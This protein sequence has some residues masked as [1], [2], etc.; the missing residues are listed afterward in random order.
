MIIDYDGERHEFEFDDI[1][2]KQAMKIEKHTGLKLTDWGDAL[3]GEDGM[4]MQ[5]LQ[6]LGWLV[7]S[8]GTGAVDDAD[9]KLAPFG[10]AFAAALAAEAAKRKAEEDAERPT[11][12]V[13]ASN[14]QT[15]GQEVPLSGYSD[16]ASP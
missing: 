15:P 5:A 2:V 12:A 11:A 13:P 14:V 3:A 4:N 8:G 9:F 6:A 16:P 1:T 7:L 10:T